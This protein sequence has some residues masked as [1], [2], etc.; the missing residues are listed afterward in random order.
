MATKFTPKNKKVQGTKSGD[1]ITWKN[2]K[3]WKSNLT[4]D[5]LA[6]NDKIDFTNS[7]YKN[8]LNGGD[9]KDT[10]KGGKKNDTI[11]GGKG[12]DT[13]YTGLATNTVVINKGDGND[14]VYCQ[15]T[16]TTIKMGSPN[17]KDKVTWQKKNNDLIMT[18]AHYKAKSDK[19]QVKEVV[20]LKNYFKDDGTIVNDNIYLQNKK[21]AK[22]SDLFKASGAL[23]LVSVS[24]KTYGSYLNETIS[25]TTSAD[26]IYGNNGN[27]SI[28]GNSGNDYLYGGNGNDTILGENGKD[29]IYG[30]AGNDYVV[31]GADNDY[32]DGG[33][34]N[35]TIL[36]EAGNDN[37]HGGADN[38][39]ISGGDGNDTIYGDAG[40]DTISGDAGNDYIDGGAG[41]DVVTG[42]TGDDTIEAS[43]GEN[44][45]NIAKGDGIDTIKGVGTSTSL[46]LNLGTGIKNVFAYQSGADYVIERHYATTGDDIVE[47]TILQDFDYAASKEK[48]TLNYNDENKALSKIHLENYDPATTKIAQVKADGSFT[49]TEEDTSYV[50]YGDDAVD[51]NI[52]TNNGNDI[53]D[54]GNGANVVHTTGGNNR[55]TSGSG[56]DEIVIGG[57]GRNVV[58]AGSGNNNVTVA[59]HDNEIT[60][61]DG[62]DVISV[63][64]VGNNV[65]T[66]GNGAKTVSVSNEG[67]GNTTITTGDGADTITVNSA[68][69]NNI[70]AGAG[71]NDITVTN[72]SS[73]ITAGNDGNTF[74][75]N[76]SAEGSQ[77]SVTSGTGADTF[78]VQKGENTITTG[79]G[80]DSMF[81]SGGTN[82]IDMAGT[83]GGVVSISGGTSTITG[84]SY[85]NTYNLNGG[86]TN[87]DIVSVPSSDN[88]NAS[89]SITGGTHTVSTKNGNDSFSITAGTNNIS[90]G[91]G[92]DNVS[93]TGGTNN[94]DLGSGKDTITVASTAGESTIVGGKGADSITVESTSNSEIWGGNKTPDA[95]G[96]TDSG[97]NTINVKVGGYHT[98]HGGSYVNTSDPDHK[99]DTINAGYG[100]NGYFSIIGGSENDSINASGA[101]R[102]TIEGAAGNDT[103]HGGEASDSYSSIRG[104]AGADSII[105]LGYGEVYGEDGDDEITIYGAGSTIDG[106]SGNDYINAS[107][108][109]DGKLIYGGSGEDTISVYGSNN[110]IYGGTDSIG[111]DADEYTVTK[112][113]SYNNNIYGGANSHIYAGKGVDTVD[114]QSVHYYK[115]DSIRAGAGSTIYGAAGRDTIYIEGAS[116]VVDGKGDNDSIENY[117]HT[118]SVTG[119]TIDGGVGDDEINITGTG[120]T[121]YGGDGDDDITITGGGNTI[122]G[123]IGIDSITVKSEAGENNVIYGGFDNDGTDV[124]ANRII[125]TNKGNNTVWG[126]NGDSVTG[127]GDYIEAGKVVGGVYSGNNTIY[128]GSRNDY[129]YARNAK[130]VSVKGGNGDDEIY[131][132]N[133]GNNILKGDEGDDVI[134]TYGSNSSVDGGDGKDEIHS[135]TVYGDTVSHSNITLRGGKG[136]D[137]LYITHKN[138]ELLVF[139]NGDGNDVVAFRDDDITP[140]HYD[141]ICFEDSELDELYA[142]VTNGGD[143]VI[144][145]NKEASTPDS[146]TLSGFKNLY[147]YSKNSLTTIK[148]KDTTQPSGYNTISITDFINTRSIINVPSTQQNYFGSLFKETIYGGDNEG[149]H[150]IYGRGGDDFID[151]GAGNDYIY[152]GDND[153]EPSGNDTIYGGTGNDSLYGDDGDDKIYADTY[154]SSTGETSLSGGENN[155]SRLYGGSGNDSLYGGSGNDSL[156]GGLGND[157]LYAQYGNNFLKGEEGDDELHSGAGNDVFYFGADSL[158]GTDTIFSGSGNDTIEIGSN[159]Y[160]DSSANATEKRYSKNGNDLVIATYIDG[161]GVVQSKVVV[162]DFFPSGNTSAKY[163][164]YNNKDA[165]LLTDM[166]IYK[167]ADGDVVT[168]LNKFNDFLEGSD[169]A[170]TFNNVGGGT[171]TD[172]YNDLVVGG[173]GNDT[174]N[175]ANT[176]GDTI[177]YAKIRIANGDGTDTIVNAKNSTKVMIEFVDPADH[178]DCYQAEDNYIIERRHPNAGNDGWIV[179]KTILYGFTYNEANNAKIEIYNGLN[180]TVVHHLSEY[181]IADYNG[182]PELARVFWDDNTS[183]YVYTSEGDTAHYVLGTEYSD[184]ITTGA[185]HD[186]IESFDGNDTINAGN[187][188][189]KITVTGYNTREITTGTGN[190]TIIAQTGHNH[191]TIAGGSNT[192]MASNDADT[193]TINGSGTNTVNLGG[194]ADNLT[195][196]GGNNTVTSTSTNTYSTENIII[197]GEGTNSVTA[198]SGG[199]E[200]VSI[201]GG[202]NTITTGSYHDTIIAG[203]TTSNTITTAGYQNRITVS[204]ADATVNVNNSNGQNVI[205]LTTTGTNVI[206]TTGTS[207]T[208]TTT[209]GNNTIT[210]KSIEN[211]TNPSSN[212]IT[213]G[214]SGTNTVTIEGDG[215]GNTIHMNST[216]TSTI[217]GGTNTD[218]INVSAGTNTINA[219]SGS[220]NI[221]ITGGTNNINMDSA[222]GANVTI[223]GAAVSTTIN[224]SNARNYYT[225]KAGTNTLNLA[226]GTGEYDYYDFVTITGGTNTVNGSE[227]E[228]HIGN[229]SGG[230]NI[231]YL[232]GGN[233]YIE[234]K[235][236]SANTIYGGYG[237]DNIE[238]LYGSN[239][240]YG[241][242]VPTVEDGASDDD[243]INTINIGG[244]RAVVYAGD[245]SW[246]TKQVWNYGTSS[247]DDVPYYAGDSI[248]AGRDL[249]EGTIYGGAGEDTIYMKNNSVGSINIEGGLGGDYIC[250]SNTGNSTIHGGDDGDTIN[251][252]TG[253]SNL[254]Y[255]DDG[256]DEI[257]V[258]NENQYA[259]TKAAT[260]YGGAGNDAIKLASTFKETLVFNAGDGDDVITDTRGATAQDVLIFN[261]MTYNGLVANYVSSDN[262]SLIIFYNGG[263]DSVKLNYVTDNSYGISSSVATI[264]ATGDPSYNPEEPSGISLTELMNTRSIYNLTAQSAE[265]GADFSGLIYNENITGTSLADKIYGYGGNDTINGGAGD[266]EIYGGEGNDTIDGGA[267]ED[268]IYGGEGNDSLLGG[269]GEDD[270]DGGAGNDELF[271]GA[272]DDEL[273]D[274]IGYNTLSGGAGND[275]IYAG[276]DTTEGAGH[277]TIA[278][279]AGDGTDEIQDYGTHATLRF[280]GIDDY[281]DLHISYETDDGSYYYLVIQYGENATDKV[282]LYDYKFDDDHDIGIKIE[283]QDEILL[284]TILTNNHIMVPESPSTSNIT[285]A[286]GATNDYIY[287]TAYQSTITGGLGNDTIESVGVLEDV[288]DSQHPELEGLVL[289]NPSWVDY[290]FN[291]NG[292]GHDLILNAR[293][294]LSSSDI[295]FTGFTHEQLSDE[296]YLDAFFEGLVCT[297]TNDGDL[298]I[299]YGTDSSITI[300]GYY[301]NP[302][303]KHSFYKIKAA[304]EKNGNEDWSDERNLDDF[305]NLQIRKQLADDTPFFG[306]NEAPEYITGTEGNDTITIGASDGKNVF[307]PSSGL[308]TVIFDNRYTDET[309]EG[310]VISGTNIIADGSL[311][312]TYINMGTAD[313]PDTL[314]FKNID[315][316]D[317]LLLSEDGNTLKI[318]YKNPEELGITAYAV[319]LRDFLNTETPGF[320]KIKLGVGDNEG[321]AIVT[322]IQDIAAAQSFKHGVDNRN[323]RAATVIASILDDNIAMSNNVTETVYSYGGNDRIYDESEYNAQDPGADTV[324]AGEGNDTITFGNR[325]GNDGAIIYGEGGNDSIRADFGKIYGGGGSDSISVYDATD[326]YAETGNYRNVTIY[327]GTEDGTGESYEDVD[328]IYA[329]QSHG[330][331]EIHGGIGSNSIRGGYGNETIYGG[332]GNDTINGATG[333]DSIMGY[334][335]ADSIF[336]DDG[337]D[338]IDGGLGNDTIYGGY[339]GNDTI[340]GGAGAD[341]ILTYKYTS[342]DLTLFDQYNKVRDGGSSEIHGGIGNDVIMISSNNNEI[343]GDAGNDTITTAKDAKT[344]YH[345]RSGN[346]DDVIRSSNRW[347]N[348]DDTIVFDD[349]VFDGTNVKAEMDYANNRLIIRYDYNNL[350][351]EWNSSITLE[352]YIKSDST[353]DYVNKRDDV[354]IQA[355]GRRSSILYLVDM[356]GNKIS[357][358]S[359]V[360]TAK[361]T[362]ITDNTHYTFFSDDITYSSASGIKLGGEGDD[363]LTGSSGNDSIFGDDSNWNDIVGHDYIDGKAGKNYLKGQAGNDTLV[364]GYDSNTDSLYGGSGDNT[365]IIKTT[366]AYQATPSDT[367]TSAIIYSDSAND[368]IYFE[369]CDGNFM[370]NQSGNDL[371]IRYYGNSYWNRVVIKDYFLNPHNYKIKYGNTETYLHSLL[372]YDRVYS[373]ASFITGTSVQNEGYTT[374]FGSGSAD[375]ISYNGSNNTIIGGAGNDSITSSSSGANSITHGGDGNDTIKA[376]AGKAFGGNGDDYIT[377][378]GGNTTVYGGA[379]ADYIN[380]YADGDDMIF[381]GEKPHGDDSISYNQRVFVEGYL[382]TPDAMGGTNSNSNVM[383][384]GGNDTI[385]AFGENIYNIDG[386]AGNDEYH[387]LL[388]NNIYINDGVGDDTLHLHSIGSKEKAY[389]VMGVN[390]G[391]S[392]SDLFVVNEENYNNWLDNNGSFTSGHG[393]V[394][395][396]GSSPTASVDTII[397]SE[398]LTTTTAKLN[399]FKEQIVAWLSGKETSVSTALASDTYRDDMIA[400]FNTFNSTD[401]LKGGWSQNS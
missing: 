108:E 179:E 300:K 124:G 243:A 157:K 211:Y 173:A 214:G 68:G 343:W 112:G 161:E 170:D 67:A 221:D 210:L 188:N 94:V 280:D 254:V 91:D 268:D 150:Y 44:I 148:Y 175:I 72:G 272:G 9:G 64:G 290:K 382:D 92:T 308:D 293:H 24:N 14:T 78:N 312:T 120:N 199:A 98:I 7:S 283:G 87:I 90:T 275:T 384:R 371:K 222:S 279:A 276:I 318:K 121:I 244:A 181:H 110:T 309:I 358:K 152:G 97:T 261:G 37:I 193:I 4:V 232:N 113:K 237:A 1:K 229:I 240:V 342:N 247:Y 242:E 55:V 390:S 93:I 304:H 347:N 245:G 335:G 226:R 192:V 119:S 73:T 100:N 172:S 23:K 387:T 208:I 375:T 212:T 326:Y 295:I 59:G 114:N 28:K 33:A 42:G 323:T 378:S 191:I 60:T 333:N 299:T 17:A 209:Q 391:G 302:L 328:T 332:D 183:K 36:G 95:N 130:S 373:A 267:G 58:D 329:G 155:T 298:V 104:G 344:R 122:W 56:N 394:H 337:D 117:Y 156:Y 41:N 366:N 22:L 372:N 115:G 83:S 311:H 282:R 379:G 71:A 143:L 346:G 25:G 82:N 194:G 12:N 330:N 224:D 321:A 219:T 52:N 271:G 340:F 241:G 352:N 144:T 49:T 123:G 96:N 230:T 315:S 69:N 11:T 129:I 103:I 38:D 270:I 5:A 101:Y 252:Y 186:I 187:G 331:N 356:N 355:G 168:A 249:I 164:K 383:G 207:N 51:N 184:A 147:G 171:H 336:G 322:T 369:S 197:G 126:G 218:T 370:F 99:G 46:T 305:A 363:T 325:Y 274:S 320:T 258:G 35:D 167:K 13:I 238:A 34:G 205:S 79:G 288:E 57:A 256:D 15:G 206:N 281:D 204:G 65:I 251:I 396:A 40:N 177:S 362:G 301:A 292:D 50:V 133:N 53:I 109:T 357:L 47:Q 178:I 395:L 266:D 334:A 201:T 102:A 400:M 257:N 213:V 351:D 233:D 368:V 278:F 284:N 248:I 62:T 142:Q 43:S 310:G 277:N 399:Q 374:R 160:S 182:T 189:N 327:G 269:A 159:F 259:G 265:Q 393:G 217:T 285:I 367:I 136:N 8:K 131:G 361:Q 360:K 66:T 63:T 255:G 185:G 234:I 385:C 313:S 319:E 225:I 45:V 134:Y 141:T 397:S 39:T 338:W 345:F 86:T 377:I 339:N 166:K 76:S 89:V 61:G 264:I 135:D 162:Q 401:T 145:Y 180:S 70:S 196:E 174:I 303:I 32:I 324:Y 176:T 165:T 19:K 75:L 27:D 236:T 220:D 386:G 200:Y 223:E 74:T 203:G 215:N 154:D 16:K 380:G 250:A 364:G 88:V 348:G 26:T 354:H 398:N 77:N 307:T 202:A 296:A 317:N 116:N 359:L 132:S 149:T 106:G 349:I 30:D 287:A 263:A 6:G 125:V 29:T 228:D 158:D 297:K 262:A 227:N 246:S 2:S 253:D 84:A 273:Q 20:T 353:G 216:G 111:T 163:V 195:I 151:G 376:Y 235:E 54:V 350:S 169:E 10:I 294:R 341:S 137:N 48:V 381:T 128:G 231:F 286:G 21:T 392:I 31:G 18:Y 316:I 388:T 291:K 105:V 139:K 107:E 190:D 80:A 138:S 260:I 3:E 153:T 314:W 118:I 146:V 389:I 306:D 85:T 239:T 127:D 140:S 81:V 365:F 289:K 198:T